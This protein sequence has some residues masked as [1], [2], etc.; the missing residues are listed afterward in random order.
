MMDMFTKLIQNS[1]MQAKNTHRNALIQSY[2]YIP[3]N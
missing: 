3:N 2:A 1:A